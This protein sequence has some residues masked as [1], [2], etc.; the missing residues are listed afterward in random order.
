MPQNSIVGPLLFLIYINDLPNCL[1]T[2]CAKKFAD[3]TNISIL[4]RTLADLEPM[5]N[6]ELVN[7][8][9][10][11]KANRLS[12]NVAKTEFMII[13]SRQ[14]LLAERS[15]EICVSLENQRIERADHTKSPGLTIDDRLS[16]SN[17]INEVCKKV[18]SAI[19][20]LKRIRPFVSHSTAIQTYNA[21]IQPHLDYYSPVWDG[22]SNQLSDK[23][24]KLQNRAARVIAK[25]NYETSSNVLLEMLKWNSLSSVRRKK[26]KTVVMFKSLNKL[27]LVYLQ[28]LFNI[29]TTN[30]NEI[31]AVTNIAQ[32]THQLSKA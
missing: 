13:G 16:W 8:N 32:A 2:A 15:D 27:A 4:G 7:L 24:Q 18:S 5:I 19:G 23:L 3:D 17:Y 14:R 25:A 21:L 6:P 22:L 30:Y 12:L 26:Q 11:L 29:R 10:W 20:A 31:R 28:D 9:C 1:T